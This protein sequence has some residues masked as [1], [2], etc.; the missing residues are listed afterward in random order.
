MSK[1]KIIYRNNEENI[2]GEKN[3]LS[4]IYHPFIVNMYFSFQDCDNLYLIMDYLSGGDLRFHIIK[5]KSFPFTENQTK[6]I[7]SN[8]ILAL[9]YIHNQKII[10]RDLKPENL[11]FDNNGYIHLTDFGIAILNNNENSFLKE[12]SGTLGYMAP[13]VVLKRGH[14]YPSD[15][16]A[17]GVIGY[18]LIIGKRPYYSKNR[19]ELKDLIL[20][21]QPKIK[22]N[23]NKKGWSGNSRDFVNKLLQRRPVKRLGYYGINEIKNHS[24]LKDV[25]WDLLKNKKVKAPYVPKGS[26]D[27]FDKKYCQEE[28]IEEKYKNLINIKQY[29]NIFDN[30]TYISI[31]YIIKLNKYDINKKSNELE[32]NKNNFNQI[33]FSENRKEFADKS[34]NKSRFKINQKNLTS[35]KSLKEFKIC[36][37]IKEDS[38]LS[39][40][41][42]K[43]YLHNSISQLIPKKI[44][45]NK[46]KN[47][48]ELKKEKITREKKHLNL[49]D[50]HNLILKSVI[51][52]PIFQKVI[53]EN[54]TNKSFQSHRSNLKS[55]K[56]EIINYKKAKSGNRKGTKLFNYTSKEKTLYSN[57]KN[58]KIV[59][60]NLSN[61]KKGIVI[62][63]K[64]SKNS[65]NDNKINNIDRKKSNEYVIL[66]QYF[67]YNKN[68]SFI[69]NQRNKKLTK[70]KPNI[71]KETVVSPKDIIIKDE[72]KINKENNKENK[73]KEYKKVDDIEN[74]INE[75][76]CKNK[77]NINNSINKKEIYKNSL[78]V[79]NENSK[80]NK[81]ISILKKFEKLCGNKNKKFYDSKGFKE[82]KKNIKKYK[83]HKKI[84]KSLSCGQLNKKEIIK[85]E[86][87]NFDKEKNNFKALK[88]D[89]YFKSTRLDKDSRNN[90][91]YII[92]NFL[93]L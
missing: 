42:S 64:N 54:S 87:N 74:R 20:S 73:S 10:H 93:S 23:I 28:S 7:I 79:H 58:L 24:W 81:Y 2:I 55:K 66:N 92:G 89:E 46:N 83:D 16:F 35:N 75:I 25:N 86:D 47:D 60:N 48:K 44:I 77:I 39:S 17:L 26:K 61:D 31:D 21:Y 67:I 37:N 9:E 40:S 70:E 71:R 53:S 14:S 50:I 34:H 65:E 8:I 78:S 30:F 57:S 85:N 11:L 18:E 13:E 49:N 22:F 80:S 12:S 27:Y 19:K 43:K 91:Y 52:S 3:I 29:E 33:R 51:S 76:K 36:V 88:F 69:I 38:C 41:N 72:D 45:H 82:Y 15:Y 5:K 62:Q 84:H 68:I 63:I 56:N 32:L 1:S 59:N 90:N 6:F 4:K